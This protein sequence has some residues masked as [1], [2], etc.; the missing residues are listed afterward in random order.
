MRP[1]AYV[2]GLPFARSD[3]VAHPENRRRDRMLCAQKIQ[4]VAK[5][6]GVCSGPGTTYVPHH[7]KYRK[8]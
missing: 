3:V 4:S 5:A 7:R 8:R 2:K 6:D 1:S